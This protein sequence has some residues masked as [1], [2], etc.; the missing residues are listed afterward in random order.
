MFITEDEGKKRLPIIP[1]FTP[2]Q[3][4]GYMPV[5]NN[6]AQ[7]P[8][9]SP[10]HFDR[11]KKQLKERIGLTIFNALPNAPLQVGAW[12]MGKLG[13]NAYLA[14]KSLTQLNE[15]LKEHELIR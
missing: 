8:T 14:E 10:T 9:V 4:E 11:Y 7:W 12:T 2:E 13:F 1:L 3:S 15:Y 5:F 6:G